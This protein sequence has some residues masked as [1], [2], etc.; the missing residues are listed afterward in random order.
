M[1]PD[2][3]AMWAK[4]ICDAPWPTTRDIV[5]DSTASQP[6]SVLNS[7][8]ASTEVA[9]VEPRLSIRAVMRNCSFGRGIEGSVRIASFTEYQVD[10]LRS[11]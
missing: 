10:S 6:C 9:S 7:S 11:G 1:G 4:A 5:V 2:S 3:V 8:V